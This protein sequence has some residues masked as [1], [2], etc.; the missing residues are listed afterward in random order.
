MNL[1]NNKKLYYIFYGASLLLG[2]LASKYSEKEA[3]RQLEEEVN[4]AIVNACIKVGILEI[5]TEE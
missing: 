2:W 4:N 1:S 3:Q 5:D